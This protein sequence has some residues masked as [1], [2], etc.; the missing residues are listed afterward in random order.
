MLIIKYYEQFTL[1][2][3]GVPDA[4]PRW[5]KVTAKKDLQ[6]NKTIKLKPITRD[7]ALEAIRERG[8]VEVLRT[9]DGVVYDT[10]DGAF[11]KKSRGFH[12][13]MNL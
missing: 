10:K 3:P 13:P 11:K 9:K 2:V 6:G 1:K 4:Y 8:L 7:E 5:G 12:I